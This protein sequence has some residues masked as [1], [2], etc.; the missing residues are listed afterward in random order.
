MML[1]NLFKKISQPFLAPDANDPLLA[2][3]LAEL[4]KLRIPAKQL[5][6]NSRKLVATSYAGNK[7]AVL[8]GRGMDFDE[9]RVYLPGDDIRLIDWRVTARSGTTHTKIYRE[10]RERPVY[11]VADCTS[12]MWF[13]SRTTF[14]AVIA[15][16]DSEKVYRDPANNGGNVS[17]HGRT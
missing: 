16:G 12:S 14:K 15:A 8:R 9:S 13:G 7:L 11:C 5:D 2:L 1:K 10:E 4:I 3:T 17:G 6:L